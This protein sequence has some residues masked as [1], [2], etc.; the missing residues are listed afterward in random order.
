MTQT[1]IAERV[2][3]NQSAVQRWLKAETSI[4]LGT[5]I[6]MCDVL[7]LEAADVLR[8]ARLTRLSEPRKLRR[9][10]DGEDRKSRGE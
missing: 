8:E 3:S 5:F 4:P 1:E 6:D 10:P 9:R 2:G 7:G